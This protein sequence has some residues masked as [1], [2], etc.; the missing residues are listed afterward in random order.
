MASSK[1]EKDDLV[2]FSDPDT[3]YIGKV[4]ITPDL[5]EDDRYTLLRVSFDELDNAKESLETGVNVDDLTEISYYEPLAPIIEFKYLRQ[6]RYLE[7]E[8]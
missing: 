6:L 5:S 8:T 3:R 2:L 7:E 1:F 4:I